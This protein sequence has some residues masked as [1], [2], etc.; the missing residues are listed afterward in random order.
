MV[1]SSAARCILLGMDIICPKC[2]EPVDHDSLHDAVDEGLF[3]DYKSAMRA[4]QTEG[5]TALGFTH[6]EATMGSFRSEAA[7]VM[8]DLLGDDMDGAASM[9]EDFDYLGMLD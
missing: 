1:V 7:S 4:F 6:N 8:Y 5:C 9:M 3:D 2:S